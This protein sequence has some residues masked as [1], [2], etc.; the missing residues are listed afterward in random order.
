[1]QNL[2]FQTRGFQILTK[3]SGTHILRSCDDKICNGGNGNETQD[4]AM[5]E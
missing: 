5:V 2:L 3:Q 1:M 4:N